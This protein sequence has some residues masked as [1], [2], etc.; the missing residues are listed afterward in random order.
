MRRSPTGAFL[1]LKDT[2]MQNVP[3]QHGEAAPGLSKME[4]IALAAALMSVTAL[5]IDIMLPALQQIGSALGVENENHRQYIISAYFAGMALALLPYGPLSDRYGRRGP[6]LIGL[7]IYIVS[8]LAAAFVTSFEGLLVLRFLQGVGAASTRVIAV[9]MVRDRFGGRQ[10]AETMSLIFMVF[11]VIPVV[12]PSIGQL[13]LLFG[14]WHLIFLCMGIIGGIITLWAAIRMPETLREEDRRPFTLGSI[15][16]AFA[17]VLTNRFSLMYTLASTFIFGALFAF[18]YQ[19][20][21]SFPLVFAVI[22]GFMAL[23]SYLNSRFVVRVG[24]RKLSHLAL[25]GFMV[26]SLVWLIWSTQGTVPFVP[27]LILFSLA[28]FQFGWV[29]GNFN[30]IAMEPLGHVAGTAASVQGFVSTLG[31]GMF[32]ALIGQAFDGTLTPI[33][34]G[35]FILG[36]LS[37]ILVLIAERGKLFQQVSPSAGKPV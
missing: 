22:A 25:T 19:L 16:S 11:M 24:M 21:S 31:S 15:G 13:M 4:F 32:G 36:V 2:G 27:F 29:G 8:A 14:N 34:A 5:A 3:A 18:I 28:M 10:M 12:A 1:V 37:L 20:G 30:A 7:G 26:V 9:S 33:A 23:S 17:V 6:L 35:Y